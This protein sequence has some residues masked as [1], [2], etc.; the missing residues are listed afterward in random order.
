MFL[1]HCGMMY[2][3][4]VLWW[5]FSTNTVK[6]TLLATM[7]MMQLKYDPEFGVFQKIPRRKK[8]KKEAISHG[9]GSS[10]HPIHLQEWKTVRFYWHRSFT[11][12][13]TFAIIIEPSYKS[14]SLQSFIRTNSS[15]S[16]SSLSRTL[17][18]KFH[19]IRFKDREWADVG[20][21]YLHTTY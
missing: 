18:E 12:N 11:T 2:L 20:Y 21:W 19:S 15:F 10:I 1:T 3:S 6:T 8:H 13:Y 7:N 4:G 14:H 9:N 17:G 16:F 5:K